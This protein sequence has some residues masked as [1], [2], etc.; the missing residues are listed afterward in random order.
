MSFSHLDNDEC[1]LNTHNCDSNATCTNTAG[2]F[3][4]ACNSGYTGNGTSCSGKNS[5]VFRYSLE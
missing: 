5:F 2:S 1:S 3:T 4:C